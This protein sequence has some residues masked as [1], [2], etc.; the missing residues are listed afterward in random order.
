MNDEI[1]AVVKCIHRIWYEGNPMENPRDLLELHK[2]LSVLW[3]EAG[4]TS[5]LAVNNPDQ[6]STED[7]ER[8]LK[9]LDL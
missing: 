6:F 2:H 3:N 1:K 4:I 8:A 9:R 5:T 7:A